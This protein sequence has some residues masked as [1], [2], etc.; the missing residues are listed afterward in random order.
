MLFISHSSKDKAAALALRNRL[1]SQGYEPGQIF[2][3]S[4]ADSG[5]PAGSKWEQFLYGRLKNCDALIVLGSTNWQ[6]SRWC[7]AE[8]VYAKAAGKLVFPV[9]LE[10]G[11]RDEVLSEYQGVLVYAEGEASYERLWAGLKNHRLNAQDTFA[12]DETR[13]PFPGLLAFD[14]SYATV[15]FGRQPETQTV[16]ELL[17]RMKARGE[18]RLLMI[19]GGSGSGKSSLLKAG[20]L[21]RLRH[22]SADAEW[23]VLPTLRFGRSP[24]EFFTGR[25]GRSKRVHR[26]ASTRH[27][28][29]TVSTRIVCLRTSLLGKMR[30]GYCLP[31]GR[32]NRRTSRWS[33]FVRPE[34]SRGTPD[35]TSFLTFHS[36]QGR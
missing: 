2:L 4:D 3:D 9:L 21:A 15:Y 19:V 32:S 34:I 10:P 5:I 28:R 14:E 23:L 35:F 11:V 31:P 36:S 8:L 20:V 33:R 29:R 16:L 1:L 18:P 17:R 12:W 25:N 27:S 26:G 7:F 24:S 30:G 22:K 6:Q 13:C